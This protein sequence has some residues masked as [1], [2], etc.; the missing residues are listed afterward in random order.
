MFLL[1]YEIEFAVV[2][3]YVDDLNFIGIFKELTKTTSYKKKEFK[4]KD[5]GKTKFYLGLHI[6][7]LPSGILLHQSTY[8]KKVLKHF[9]IDEA[10]P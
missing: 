2:A 3:V 9:Y 6:K 1:K 4:I 5:L 7:Y 10:Y 8:T